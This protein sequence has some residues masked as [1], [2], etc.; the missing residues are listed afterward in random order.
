MD[1][2]RVSVGSDTE[3]PRLALRP[4]VNTAGDLF[5]FFSDVWLSFGIKFHLIHGFSAVNVSVVL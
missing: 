2:T 3:C 1:K 5:K 4:L